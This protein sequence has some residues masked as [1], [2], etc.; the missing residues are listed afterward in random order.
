MDLPPVALV[1]HGLGDLEEAGD[2]AARHERGEL[3][4]TNVEVL[5]GG[6]QAVLEGAPHDVLEA[7]VDL[8]T[9]PVEALTTMLVQ[10]S[11][12]TMSEERR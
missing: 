5:A 9:G 8:F 10:V 4:L 3:A 6:V 11:M 7:P 2:V 1:V 12:V